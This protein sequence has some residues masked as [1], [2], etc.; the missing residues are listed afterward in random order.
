MML[1]LSKVTSSE[2]TCLGV[3]PAPVN[4][5]ESDPRPGGAGIGGGKK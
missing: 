5:E 3:V 2:T 4:G 1:L